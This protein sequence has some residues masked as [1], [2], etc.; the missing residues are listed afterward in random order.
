QRSAWQEAPGFASVEDSSQW[1]L[2]CYHSGSVHGGGRTGQ[3][4]M[5]P[6]RGVKRM[7][8]LQALVLAAVLAALPSLALADSAGSALGV[9]QQAAARLGEDTRTLRVGSDIF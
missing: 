9:K 6:R 5:C 4:K 2:E 3:P 7:R 8:T 1:A